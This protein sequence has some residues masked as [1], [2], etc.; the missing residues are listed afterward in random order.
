[1]ETKEKNLEEYSHPEGVEVK[2]SAARANITIL[3]NLFFFVVGG[4]ILFNYIWGDGSS[5]GAGYELGNTVRLQAL[6]IKGTIIM[7][8]CYIVY[9]LLQY[10][11]LYWFTGKDRRALHWNTD[12][13]TLG[14]LVKKPLLLK[15][16]RIA[17]LT[18]FVLIGLLPFIH[19]LCTGNDVCFFIGVFCVVGSGADCYYFWKLRSFNGNDKIVDGNESLSATIIKG[20]Y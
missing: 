12:W 17:L 7:A 5:Y 11:L 13:K 8:L 16:Y 9:T 1:M 18:P 3:L 6:S 20:S 19:G 2:V 4:V 14:F 10:G 15:Y